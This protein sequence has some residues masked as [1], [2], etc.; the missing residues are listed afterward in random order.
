LEINPDFSVDRNVPRKP[1]LVGGVKGHNM[2][3]NYLSGKPRHVAGELHFCRIFEIVCPV[4]GGD[5][6]YPKLHPITVTEF[7]IFL[8]DAYKDPRFN[9]EVDARL[10]F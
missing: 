8:M 4:R 7:V 9:K 1:H 10:W 2:K 5:S 3:R 6:T